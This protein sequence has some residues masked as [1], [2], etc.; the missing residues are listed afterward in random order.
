MLKKHEMVDLAVQTR[1]NDMKKYKE[2]YRPGMIFRSKKYPW[3][4]IIIDYVYYSRLCDCAYEF[5]AYSIIDWK[6]ANVDEFLKYVSVS[7]GVDYNWLKNDPDSSTFPFAFF[8]EKRQDS[9]DRYI[10]EYELEYSGQCDDPVKIFVDN[11]TE[12]HGSC[13]KQFTA[14]ID[15]N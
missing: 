2:K 7:K 10:K 4:D 15:T 3:A 6:R 11:E 12:Y 5:N 13:D 1:K 9:M 8:G 14:L